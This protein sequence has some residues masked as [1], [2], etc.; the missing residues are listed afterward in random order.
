[1]ITRTVKGRL[2]IR[3]PQCDPDGKAASYK[4][5]TS[6]P[7]EFSFP[8]QDWERSMYNI[9]FEVVGIEYDKPEAA[10]GEG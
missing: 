6:S 7:V 8:T 3:I 4:W 2:I 10:G 9:A 1:M 5:A